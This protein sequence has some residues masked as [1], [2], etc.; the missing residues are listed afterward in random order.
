MA[1]INLTLTDDT[2]S[3]L[4]SHAR[5]SGMARSAMARMLIR[6]GLSRMEAEERRRILAADYAAGRADNE[7]LLEEL[8]PSQ[9]EILGDEGQ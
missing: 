5:R 4:D 8:E 2:A 9:T 7:R 6:E 1:R 3:R